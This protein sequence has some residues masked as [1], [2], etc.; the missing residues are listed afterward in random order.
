MSTL[1]P[2][3]Y[4]TRREVVTAIMWCYG[5]SKRQAKEWLKN[6][7]EERC[8]FLVEGWKENCRKSFYKD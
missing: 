7:S 4:T 2:D 1:T 8:R 6:Y 5:V 3:S